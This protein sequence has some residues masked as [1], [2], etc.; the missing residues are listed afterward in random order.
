MLDDFIVEASY[1]ELEDMYYTIEDLESDYL[2]KSEISGII[3]M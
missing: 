2:T 1:D 3:N